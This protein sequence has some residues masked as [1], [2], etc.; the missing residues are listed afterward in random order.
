M[1]LFRR[2]HYRSDTTEFL[3]DLKAKHPNLEAQQ[4]PRPRLVVGPCAK[5]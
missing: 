3:D 2:P 4:R 5:P 1:P